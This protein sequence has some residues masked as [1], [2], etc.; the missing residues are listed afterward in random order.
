MSR[1][2]CIAQRTITY[3]GKESEKEHVCIPESL[4]AIPETKKKHCK[5]T[6]SK[7]FFSI[8]LSLT[9]TFL[10]LCNNLNFSLFFFLILR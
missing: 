1:T 7:F 9:A 8:A 2:Y 4:C 3:N 5:S 6:T 10:S